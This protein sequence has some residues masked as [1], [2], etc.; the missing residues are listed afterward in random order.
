MGSV[1]PAMAEISSAGA[2]A[3][4]RGAGFPWAIREPDKDDASRNT[5]RAPI[6]R[7]ATGEGFTPG[8]L[9]QR[10]T[11]AYHDGLP[12]DVASG[13]GT[14]E[15]DDPGEVLRFGQPARGRAL[16]CPL[17]PLRR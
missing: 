16:S 5:V 15:E 13:L 9:F 8:K 3:G 7:L 11:A 6:R 4:F 12:G 1:C 10:E 17:A 2:G 14:E